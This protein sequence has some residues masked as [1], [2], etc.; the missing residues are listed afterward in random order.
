MVHK[1][2]FLKK[3][4]PPNVGK[5][6]KLNFTKRMACIPVFA[7]P[8][9]R[10]DSDLSTVNYGVQFSQLLVPHDTQPLLLAL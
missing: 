10:I 4:P 7:N 9:P 6:K 3:V 2:W 5:A 8:R 1:H